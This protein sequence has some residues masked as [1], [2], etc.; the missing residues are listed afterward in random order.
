MSES[1]LQPKRRQLIKLASASLFLLVSP[2]GRAAVGQ[3]PG[4]LAVRVWPAADYTRVTI[5]HREPL[6]LL[7]S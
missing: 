7:I 1:I 2:A 3:L 5:E 6:K 4:I